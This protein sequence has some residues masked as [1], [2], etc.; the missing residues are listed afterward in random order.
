MDKF[1]LFFILYA[2]VLDICGNNLSDAPTKCVPW[3][4]IIYQTHVKRCILPQYI[5]TY[6]VRTYTHCVF[7]LSVNQLQNMFI[8]K[9]K[10]YIVIYNSSP[11]M[12]HRTKNVLQKDHSASYIRSKAVCSRPGRILNSTEKS[13]P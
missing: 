11:V 4:G 7:P 12:S 9:V 1:S 13:I 8:S 2:L 3:N 10:H 5:M 6:T